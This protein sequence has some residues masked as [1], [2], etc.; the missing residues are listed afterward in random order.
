[1]VVLAE[2]VRT[3][4]HVEASVLG[5]QV[6][7]E[8]EAGVAASSPVRFHAFSDVEKNVREQLEKLNAH[9]WVREELTIRG[10][11]FDVQSGRLKEVAPV[12]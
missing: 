12:G 1:M 5:N 2:H 10:F 3:R 6:R 11:V 4:F 9:S 7:I 8:Q